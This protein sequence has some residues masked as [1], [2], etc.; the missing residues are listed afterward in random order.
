MIKDIEIKGLRGFATTQKVNFAKPNGQ[1]GSG[2]SLFVGSNNAGKSTVLEAIRAVTQQEPPSL[3]T[4]RRNIEAGDEV[5]IKV[6]DFEDDTIE[7]K[8]DMAGSSETVFLQ[9]NTNMNGKVFVLNSR[10]AFDPFFSKSSQDRE[11]YITNY[12]NLP[13][14]RL[15]TINE[16]SF[17]LFYANQNREKFNQL[18]MEIINPVPDWTIDLTD[19]SQYY[20]KFSKGTIKHSSEGL[21]EGLISLFFIIDALYDSNP[22]DII[23]ID[24]PELS[25]H[26]TYQ[27]RLSKLLAKMAK[28]RQIIVATH[29]PYFVNLE[30]L[31]N[32]ATISRVHIEN[33][34][35]NVSQLSNKHNKFI[36]GALKDYRNPH[37]LGLNAREV[38]FLE[39]NV[40]LVEGQEDI[41]FYSKILEQLGLVINGEFFGWGTGGAAKMQNFAEI[42][43]EL[44]FKKVIG[45]LDND[46]P[47]ERQKLETDFPN[48]E[49]YCIPAKDV[50]TK[51]AYQQER[52]EGLLDDHNNNIRDEY[53][54]KTEE[55]FKKINQYLN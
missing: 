14:Q 31:A 28:D 29:S 52:V 12:S 18:L 32:G 24:E 41:I 5:Y 33:G 8:S 36:Q 37:T 25:L 7:L 22:E 51:P 27:K 1:L 50:R 9:K 35:S 46:K 19:N 30:N 15:N 23:V 54:M 39:D 43:Q 44:G 2:L 38:F 40:I 26:P 3:S 47:E 55:M 13:N 11:G 34:T 48:Y 20:L 16:F 21:G 53:K 45:I 4:G 10:R 6:T 42:L 17:R 49:F